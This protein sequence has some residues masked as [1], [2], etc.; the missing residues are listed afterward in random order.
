MLLI[1]AIVSADLSCSV[2]ATTLPPFIEGEL[3]PSEVDTT[4]SASTTVGLLDLVPP[5]TPASEAEA[6][7]VLYIDMV[8]CC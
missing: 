5:L 6:E 8:D 2:P 3:D 1:L 7:A 4:L